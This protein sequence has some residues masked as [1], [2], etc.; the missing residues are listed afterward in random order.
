MVTNENFTPY[1]LI[2][3]ASTANVISGVDSVNNYITVTTAMTPG[4]ILPVQFTISGALPTT[5]PQ[6]YVARDY[7]ISVINANNVRV[8]NST[9]DAAANVNFFIISSAGSGTNNVVPQ[10][11][12]TFSAITFENKPAFDFNGGYAAAYFYS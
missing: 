12:W 5:S 3:S 8:F 7:F 10:N 6:I 1:Q 2:R 4:Q 9:A 11:T